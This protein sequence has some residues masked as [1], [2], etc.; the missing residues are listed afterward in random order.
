M[1]WLTNLVLGVVLHEKHIDDAL[2]VHEPVLLELL[3]HPGAE[4][5]DGEGDVVHGLDLGGLGGKSSNVS[6]S[7]VYGPS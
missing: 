1:V 4:G 2:L 7:I 6:G 3:S 5:G